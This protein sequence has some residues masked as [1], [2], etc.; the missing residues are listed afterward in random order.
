MKMQ[1]PEA[2][3]EEVLDG[4]EEETGMHWIVQKMI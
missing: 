2:D 3:T 1:E 4:E